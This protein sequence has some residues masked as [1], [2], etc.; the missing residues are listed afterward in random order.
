MSQKES[1]KKIH[2]IEVVRDPSINRITMPE[3]MTTRDAINSLYLLAE[4]ED[5]PVA[6]S[7]EFNAFP[8]DG[9][10][11]LSKAL[12]R[13]YGW[14]ILQSRPPESFFDAETPPAMIGME[15]GP[16]ETIQVPWGRIG[17]PG[18]EG[19]LETEAT[20]KGGRLVFVL[21]G[22]VKRKHEAEV[23]ELANDVRKILRQESVY[24][25]K[26]ILVDFTQEKGGFGP[27][28]SPPPKFMDLSGIDEDELVFSREVANAIADSVFTPIEETEKCK[29]AGVP[30]KRGVLLAGPY[31][32]GKTLTARV[33]AVKAER[34]GWTFV[35]LENVED[36]PQAIA[37]ARQYSPAVIF[38]EDIDRVCGVER[39][40]EANRILNTIDGIDS[41]TAELLVVLTTNH[42]DEIHDAMLRPGR[43]DHKIEVLPPDKAAAER[44]IRIYGRGLVADSVDLSTPAE[45]LAGEKPATIRE[46]VE[47]SKLSAI[48]AGR[49]NDGS[50]VI[51]AE[52]LIHAAESLRLEPQPKH[53][54]R[55]HRSELE[56]IAQVIVNGINREIRVREHAD[57]LT[58][59]R[60][61]PDLDRVLETQR[62]R[63]RELSR[64]GS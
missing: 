33:A 21:G 22:K 17:L 56:K 18:V 64:T 24:R 32:V 25:G 1:K 8:L 54:D 16:H 47:R 63:E 12:D 27:L 58:G 3:K 26:A 31:G 57:I 49:A 34:H 9:A 55:D 43:L 59:S 23:H 19:H 53:R 60:S 10:Y 5:Q 30:L 40:E 38:A 45:M 52:D 6:I 51:L 35:Y 14:S 29:A 20:M 46:A 2:R 4:Q 48:R 42:V 41:K 11:A 7:E 28:P 36:L 39:T 15:I 61:N 62:D 44:L 50:L 37:F 13:K